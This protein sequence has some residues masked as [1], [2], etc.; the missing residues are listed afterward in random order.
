MFNFWAHVVPNEFLPEINPMRKN[1]GFREHQVW[2]KLK[3]SPPKLDP[4]IW[5]LWWGNFLKA[6]EEQDQTSGRVSSDSIVLRPVLG[7][8]NEAKA[9]V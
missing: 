3:V 5:I 1:K 8:E 7:H 2:E 6:L 9:R 4:Q